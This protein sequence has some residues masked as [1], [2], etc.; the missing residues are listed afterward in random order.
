VGS[1]HGGAVAALAVTL[2]EQEHTEPGWRAAHLSTQLLRPVTRDGP[3][4]ADVRLVRAGRRTRLVEVDV[5]AAG[6]LVSRTSLLR[7]RQIDG[8][9][10][11]DDPQVPADDPPADDPEGM[12]R[13]APFSIVGENFMSTAMDIRTQE[14]VFGRNLAWFR[15]R[16]EV[17]PGGP[18]SP[19]ARAA[20]AADFG[21]GLSSPAHVGWPPRITFVNADLQLS[22]RRD[23][24]GPWVRMES[25]QHWQP[26]ATGVAESRLWD[27][28]GRIGSARQHLVLSAT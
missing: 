4:A 27:H 9:V 10:G 8:I 7:I 2:L 23:P 14:G 26:D 11:V 5:T 19:V 1:L 25:A 6:T 18:P 15:L 28:R 3:L 13:T 24:G 16:A 20:A 21:N 17:V 22:L 12:T